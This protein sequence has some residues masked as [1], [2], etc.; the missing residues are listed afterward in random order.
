MG[1]GVRGKQTPRSVEEQEVAFGLQGQDTGHAPIQ[2]A[3]WLLRVPPADD[4]NGVM[5]IAWW[6]RSS[7]PPCIRKC[8]DTRGLDQSNDTVYP[9]TG[10]KTSSASQ[11]FWGDIVFAQSGVY[12]FFGPCFWNPEFIRSRSR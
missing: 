9:A 12:V 3:R 11:G 8:F 6:I 5:R 2:E 7:T 1:W 10:V 4:G